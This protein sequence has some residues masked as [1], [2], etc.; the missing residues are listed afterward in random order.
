MLERFLYRLYNF[1]ETYDILFAS[2]YGIR[3]E[4]ST[5]YATLELTDS[6]VNA[7]KDKHYALAVSI[8]FSKV[9]DTLVLLNKI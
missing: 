9:F 1:F 6:V 4:R 8:D 5:E 3:K 2:R 7:L